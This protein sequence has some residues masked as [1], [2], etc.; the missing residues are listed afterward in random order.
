MTDSY[1]L[2]IVGAGLSALSFLRAGGGGGET[3][4]VD[5]RDRPGGW[6]QPAVPA[7][8]LDHAAEIID[9]FEWPAKV[10]PLLSATAVGLL[11]A[12]SG[13]HTILVRTADGTHHLRATRIL[14]ASGGL[15]ITREHDQ[16][17]GSR[18]VGITT[19][20]FIFQTLDRGYLPGHRAL[21]YGDSRY[22]AATRAALTRNGVTLAGGADRDVAEPSVATQSPSVTTQSP[23]VAPP[24]RPAWSAGYC[25][26]TEASA[27]SIPPRPR[28]GEGVG[29]E[30]ILEIRGFPR[31][32]AIVVRHNGHTSEIDADLLVYAR[33]MISNTLWL[34]GSGIDLDPDG[35]IRIDD[36]YR[37]NLPGIYAIG[38]VVAPDLDHS[39]SIEMG[40]AAARVLKEES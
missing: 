10:D 4:V 15:E 35:R 1:D 40:E 37:T 17:P 39:R 38:T 25:V 6:L 30:G 7:P 34:K 23:S 16:I 27:T 11:P 20:S 5:Y 19:P 36:R 8:G 14:I 28:T 9:A 13:P 26:R 31:L 32:E 22:A 29:G 2:A 12:F 21:V 33:G 18:P 3:A 24:S